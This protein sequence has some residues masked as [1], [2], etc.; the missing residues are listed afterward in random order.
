MRWFTPPHI[1]ALV[2]AVAALAAIAVWTRP[3]ATEGGVYG[4]R[5]AGTMLGAF[6]LVLAFFAWNLA[7]WSAAS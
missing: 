6:A 1:M 2:A 3:V 7:T 5:I 4:R